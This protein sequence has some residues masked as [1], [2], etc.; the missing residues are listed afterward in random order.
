MRSVRL[1]AAAL[2]A[3]GSLA[4]AAGPAQAG[5]Y[6]DRFPEQCDYECVMYPC[7]PDD[8]LPFLIDQLPL[9]NDGS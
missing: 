7:Y 6:C 1:L 5:P 8:Y 3:A 4:A 2:F 9:D